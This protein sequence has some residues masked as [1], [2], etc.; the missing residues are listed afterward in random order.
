MKKVLLLLL[1]VG[2]S[3][4]TWQGWAQTVTVTGQ[5]TSAADN[6]P[7][8]GVG[9]VV[10]GTTRGTFTDVS[11]QYTIQ[12]SEGSTLVFRFIGYTTK[13]MPVGSSST[14]NVA[15][16]E[17]ARSLEEV[18]VTAFGI[19]QEKRALGYSVQE[20][21][22]RDI[23]ETQQ[24]NIVNTMQGKVAGV[25]ITNSGGA[26][27]ASAIMLI[28]GG[29]SLS[30]NN[31]PLYVVD[32]IPVDNTTAVGQGGL[33]A[34]TAP[35]S[36]RAIDINP[37]DIE[38][39]SV[40]K[41]PSAA[42]LY[43][44]RAAEGV[45]VITT[46][47][48]T[49][50]RARINYSNSFSFD[51]VNKLP[52]L[53]SVYKQGEQGDFDPSAMG[54]WGPQF[55]AGE[56]I[57][58]NLESI[59]QTA[60]TQKH[61]LSVSGGNDRSTFYGSASH[62]DQGGIVDNTSLER[63]SFRVSA[64]TKVGEKLKV[65]GSANYIKTGRT[66]VSQG[67]ANGVMGAVYWP[68]NDDMNNY[69]NPDGTQR[70]IATNDNPVWGIYNKPI[71]S[72]VDRLIAIGNVVY[73]PFEFLNITYRLGTDYY[74]DNFKS[75]R[76][77]GTTITGEE[78][79]ALSQSTTNNQITTSTLLVTAKK[80]FGETINTS[81]TLGHNVESRHRQAATWYGRNFIAPDFVGIN[82]VVESD[83]T[84]SQATERQRI[85]GVFADLNLDW[86][87][88][89]FL[90]FRGRNDWSS[91][92]PVKD[93][94][95]FYPAVSTS[96]IVTD[97]LEDIG[98][99]SGDNF[100]SFAKVRASWARVGKDALPHVLE[101]TLATSTNSFTI[102]PRGFISNANDYYG[103]PELKPEFTNSFEVGADLRFLRNRLGL[104]V[105]YYKTSTDEQILGTRLPPSSGGFL[106]YLNGG[107]IDNEG[108]E[109]MVN[110]QLV[111]SENFTWALDLNFA[112][113]KSTVTSLPG[114]LDRVEL[115]DAW[116]AGQ[117][118]QGAAFLGGT[119]FG[120]NGNVW[121]RNE[122]GQL[123][124]NNEGYPQVQSTLQYIGDRNPDWTGGITNTF[125][126]KNA[127]SL[128]FLWDVRI[129]GDIYNATEN[130]LVR[131]GLS[132]KTLNRGETKVFEGI[133][134]STG[135]PN[136][137]SVVLDQDY[138]Q[139]IYP[140]QGYDFVED[141][142]W[143]RLRY[144]TLTYTLPKRL[145]EKTPIN[146]LQ[147]F[148]TARNLILITDYSGVDPE[149]SGSGAGVGGSGSFGFDNLGV[150]ATRGFDLGLRL[151]L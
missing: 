30:G 28:R 72:D 133:I 25:Q 92:L 149:V 10:K 82:N 150:P 90:N 74:T 79:G 130:V 16:Q 129:G 27:G 7:L 41:G 135:E 55:E 51:V 38:S 17:D 104:D 124:L 126:Y 69:L 102:A 56:T 108:V 64:D 78:K 89:A 46:K 85:V 77:P 100:L 151:T 1:L 83:R 32:G 66:Y 75:V 101:T 96:I 128:S 18:V 91:T 6:T 109:I 140:F 76:M 22:S 105:T 26:P 87:G 40:L 103:N 65:G 116:A 50:G 3:L 20:L 84:V 67:S 99:T 112:K 110:T 11:G 44:L 52:E 35:A 68:R 47:R 49:G 62:Y 131:S 120:I 145:L 37:E 57:Y 8:P 139:T 19:E 121:K 106:A 2:F 21:Q 42:A 13:E 9:V 71:S 48:G 127:L 107:Q 29:T 115:S 70:T 125:T 63:N 97:L 23:T 39:I 132:T 147:F 118:A 148:G 59:F 58:D 137:Q 123:L 141:G 54:S 144:V 15:L 93:Q 5:V 138:Y 33:D 94:S 14:I 88:I 117:V 73:D 142:S 80:T 122:E 146:S 34:G 95:F 31:Q 136:T 98:A 43:G 81:L 134:E 114:T 111:T 36:N 53:Q 86:K 143:W 61:D 45:V 12:A 113:N 4:T 60:F 119:L 24:P